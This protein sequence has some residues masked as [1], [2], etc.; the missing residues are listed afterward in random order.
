MFDVIEVNILFS[1]QVE[2]SYFISYDK[3]DNILPCLKQK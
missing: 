1:I 2:Y 3:I